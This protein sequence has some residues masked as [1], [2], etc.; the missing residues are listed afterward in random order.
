MK[1]V[2]VAVDSMKDSKSIMDVINDLPWAMDDVILLHVQ[3]L[4]GNSLMTAMLGE[5]EMKTLKESL[6]GTEYKD[7]LNKRAERVLSYYKNEF[8][9]LGMTSIRTETREGNPSDE[10]LKAADEE[11]VD[12]IIVGCSGKSRLHRLVTGC[13]SREVEKNSKVPVIVA[14]GNGC[15]DHAYLW[16]RREAYAVR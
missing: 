14:K 7:N 3:Q 5:A 4:E 10:I 1:K 13:T 8:N 2:L 16:G 6:R 9:K 11:K 15:G 12:L